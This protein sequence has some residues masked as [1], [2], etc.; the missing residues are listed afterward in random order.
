MNSPKHSDLLN[1]I[2]K[3]IL[4]TDIF[5]YPLTFA[6]IYR[7]LEIETTAEEVEAWLSRAIAQKQLIDVDGFYC[8]PHRAELVA[9]RRKRERASGQ[10]WPHA[11]RYGHW[12]AGLPFVRLVAVTGSLAVNNPRDGVDDID[13]LIV[14]QAG[15]LW[16]CR[17]LIILLVKI[18]R[19]QGVHLC[20]NYLITENVLNFDE[21]FFT[22]R[23][24]LQMQP[25]Y[26]QAYYV[27]MR[28]TN[29]WVTDYFPQGD[30]LNLEKMRDVLSPGQQFFKRASEFVLGGFL[31]TFLEKRVQEFHIAKHT[32]QA[33]TYGV[34]DKVIFTP[35]VCKG[36]YDGH[37]NKTMD[38]YKQRLQKYMAQRSQPPLNGKTRD[39]D[40][41]AQ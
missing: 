3:P 20:P 40:G 17:A 32:R 24:M 10:L 18:G 5:D 37:G 2:I 38:A 23:E 34:R 4:Y 29:G 15:R 11:I 1:E 28:E 35:D 13:Y 25:L 14:T 8:L 6:E 16:L 36:H 41:S 30:R 22:A 9:K 33:E 26:G 39:F 12:M 27:K 21:S 31:G 19:R 7:F